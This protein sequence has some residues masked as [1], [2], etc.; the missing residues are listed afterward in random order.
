MTVSATI[1]TST[2]N[3]KGSRAQGGGHTD[4]TSSGERKSE[5]KGNTTSKD[6][7]GSRARKKIPP[8]Q[9]D[10]LGVNG[11]QNCLAVGLAS[12]SSDS[13]ITACNSSP[14][15]ALDTKR[16][17]MACV[18]AAGVAG[19]PSREVYKSSTTRAWFVRGEITLPLW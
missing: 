15:G 4:P 13:G 7:S 11:N 5:Q 2:S 18:R 16:L 3:G 10:E 9:Q 8:P 1:T 12:T 17:F 6:A 14:T 19:Y